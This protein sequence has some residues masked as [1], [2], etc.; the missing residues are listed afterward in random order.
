MILLLYYIIYAES[1]SGRSSHAQIAY[2]HAL[3]MQ[4]TRTRTL[5]VLAGDKKLW[6]S[7]A[8]AHLGA[9]C[10]QVTCSSDWRRTCIE[11]A[12]LR[13]MR[14]EHKPS[15]ATGG[16]GKAWPRGRWGH[17]V[18][19][20]DEHTFMVFGGECAGATNDVHVY[21]CSKAEW[22]LVPCE[23]RYPS[24]RFGH[25]CVVYDSDYVLFGGSDGQDY[26]DD[27]H[28]LDVKSWQWRQPEVTG[29]PPPARSSHSMT[30]LGHRAFVFGGVGNDSAATLSATLPTTVVIL[31]LIDW[32]WQHPRVNG[33][34]R[35]KARL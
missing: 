6:H 10:A 25:A 28:C 18:T 13:N 21:D 9:V 2:A 32:S 22:R 7:L 15:P 24:A 1:V 5:Q 35:T 34:T 20:L 12:T 17:T 26:F 31:D 27:L 33:R 3:T 16:V 19:V 4:H 29:P 23:G 11:F 8:H 14:W 30:L